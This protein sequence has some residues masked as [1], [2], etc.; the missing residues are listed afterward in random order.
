MSQSFLPNSVVVTVNGNVY[1]IP[2]EKYSE[3]IQMLQKWS[4]IQASNKTQSPSNEWNMG[5][6]WGGKQIIN[7]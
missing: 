6:Q 1:Y 5:Q 7:D 4:S 3:L 2:S